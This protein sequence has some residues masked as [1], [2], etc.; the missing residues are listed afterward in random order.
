MAFFEITPEVAGGLGQHTVVEGE[1][2]PPGVT[3]LHY[4]FY[5]W[6]GD[7]ILEAFPCV[8][9]TDRLREAIENE[10]LSGCQFDAV[11]VST[12]SEFRALFPDTELPHFSWLRLVGEAGRDDFGFGVGNSPVVSERALKCLQ[13]FT[14]EQCEVVDYKG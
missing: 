6:L 1:D 3:K 10:A 9:V 13:R 12:T 8:I 11:R 7:D 4:E 5:G 14:L 2:Y